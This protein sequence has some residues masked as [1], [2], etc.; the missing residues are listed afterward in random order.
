MI[1]ALILDWAGTMVDDLAV[2][3]EATNDAIRAFGGEA[4]DLETYRRE[5]R[6]PVM[7]FFA[8]RTTGATLEGVDRVFFAAYE[9]RLSELALFDGIE[10]LLRVAHGRGL[11]LYVLSTVPSAV[12]DRALR[13]R[14]LRDLFS[15]L[16]GGAEDKRRVLPRLLEEAGVSPDRALFVGDTVH[17]VETALAG[18]AR[19]GAILHGYSLE[20]DLRAAGPDYV[21]PDAAAL[22]R[23]LDREFLLDTVPLVIPTVGGILVAP[24]GRILLV[25]TTKWS[26]TWGI[27]GGK[28]DYGETM[29]AA[30]EREIREETGLVAEDH[31]FLMIQDC[32]ESPEFVKKRHFLLLNWISRV[33]D[34]S[35]LA[36]NYELADARW[37]T[38]A[39]AMDMHLNRP[40][41]LVLEE[42][43]RQGQLDLG[44]GAAR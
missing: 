34:P 25:R 40:T 12:L 39:E 43:E 5:F 4:V 16:Y 31:R 18:G 44:R 29:V 33:E 14:G 1:E 3:L 11:A 2:T 21:F 7:E 32:I 35:T 22:A 26:G 20:A 38:P 37:V 13:A 24:D 42:A 19:A 8:P 36:R 30:Y 9:Q 10:D 17:D 23:A 6:I 27:P 15:G 41:R 28:I